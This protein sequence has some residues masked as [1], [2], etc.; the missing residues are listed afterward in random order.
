M[1]V[2]PNALPRRRPV[3]ERQQRLDGGRVD[4]LGPPRQVHGRVPKRPAVAEQVGLADVA[5]VDD[6]L[7]D[8]LLGRVAELGQQRN[9]GLID[10]FHRHVR[11]AG[12]AGE[13]VEGVEARRVAALNV[14]LCGCGGAGRWMRGSETCGEEQ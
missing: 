5:R 10:V 13:G 14:N 6:L 8:R 12:G 1:Q 11:R 2:V 4:P 9:V 7:V 3:L